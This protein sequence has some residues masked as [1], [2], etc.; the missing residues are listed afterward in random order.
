MTQHECNTKQ[1]DTT[2]YKKS[3]TQ[4]NLRTTLHKTTK[5]NYNTTQNLFLFVYIVVKYF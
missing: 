2:R 1:R 5:H 3:V 4:Q